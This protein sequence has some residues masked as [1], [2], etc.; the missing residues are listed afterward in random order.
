[1]SALARLPRG[2]GDRL[3]D[4]EHSQEKKA[5]PTM[6]RT[7]S[8][9][10][11]RFATGCEIPSATFPRQPCSPVCPSCV[12]FAMSVSWSLLA[13]SCLV[14]GSSGPHTRANRKKGNTPPPPLPQNS[15]RIPPSTPQ[16]RLSPPLSPASCCFR[17][18]PVFSPHGPPR[19]KAPTQTLGCRALP[20]GRWA[21]AHPSA[22]TQEE[23]RT[24]RKV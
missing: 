5:A 8:S 1:M 7:W 15:T 4:V 13:V 14:P 16:E 19:N 3:H 9:R 22:R 17:Y 11:A 12:A 20:R 23:M 10:G 21:N 18:T 2:R 6:A 24:V